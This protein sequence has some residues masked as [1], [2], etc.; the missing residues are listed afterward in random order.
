[1][2]LVYGVGIN[3]KTRISKKNGTLVKEYIIWRAMLLRCYLKKYHEKYPTYIDCTVSD[4]FKN[5]SYFYDWCQSQIGFK[6]NWDLDKDLLFIG[7]KV[8]SETTCVFLP[9][10]INCSIK[11]ASKRLSGLPTG[12][13]INPWSG[14]YYCSIKVLGKVKHIGTY[15]NQLDAFHAYKAEKEKHIKYLCVKYEGLIDH[16]AHSAL[17]NHKLSM[18]D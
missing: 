9:K 18:R 7:N 13:K 1:M 4:N 10:E 6:N 5:Y 11:Q 8:Y 3:N 2:R 16:R 17:K 14:R 12:V 15:N